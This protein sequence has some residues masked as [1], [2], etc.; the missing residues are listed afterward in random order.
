MY[1]NQNWFKACRNIFFCILFLFPAFA[2]FA[3]KDPNTHVNIR[4]RDVSDLKVANA[5]LGGGK[6]R[7]ST[8]STTLFISDSDE[9]SR[10]RAFEPIKANYDLSLIHI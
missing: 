3:P 1:Q 7:G 9:Y 6:Q 4:I 5:N 8:G 2:C 10:Y